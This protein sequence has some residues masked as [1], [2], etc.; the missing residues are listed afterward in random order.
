M[1]YSSYLL[2]YYQIFT[3]YSFLTLPIIL[4]YLSH[5]SIV[6]NNARSKQLISQYQLHASSPSY[7][8]VQVHTGLYSTIHYNNSVVDLTKPGYLI[9]SSCN[10]MRLWEACKCYPSSK[11]LACLQVSI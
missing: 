8:D 3:Y 10:F 11:R 4:L 7:T 2:F 5:L 1:D 9:V 6:L